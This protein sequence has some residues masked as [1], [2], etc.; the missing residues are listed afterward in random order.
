MQDEGVIAQIL[1]PAGAKDVPLG[2]ILAIVVD[3]ADDIAAFKDYV[4]EEGSAPA[5]A[6]P[7][8]PEPAAPSTPA[9][10]QQAAAPSKPAAAAPSGG[11]RTF[12]S[13]LA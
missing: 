8:T 9:P 5:Q 3:D 7:A 1:Y 6:A 10:A 11:A 4:Q 12:A 13:P 2:K